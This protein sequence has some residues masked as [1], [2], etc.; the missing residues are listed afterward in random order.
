MSSTATLKP[1][2]YFV[3]TKSQE[4][5]HVGSPALAGRNGPAAAPNTAQASGDAHDAGHGAEPPP[6]MSANACSPT[7]AQPAYFQT[8]KIAASVDVAPQAGGIDFYKID[9]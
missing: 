9:Q 7:W 1:T 5:L 2:R 3:L 6:A 4:S 8:L